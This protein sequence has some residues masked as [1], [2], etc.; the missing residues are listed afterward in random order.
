MQSPQLNL[1][2]LTPAH[3]PLV[4]T[5]PD[6]QSAKDEARTAVHFRFRGLESELEEPTSG[7]AVYLPETRTH[8]CLWG[9]ELTGVLLLIR[10]P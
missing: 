1:E 3:F 5:V 6:N 4:V 2:E 8:H 9:E 10:H 7:L